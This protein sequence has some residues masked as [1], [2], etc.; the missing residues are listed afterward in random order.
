MALAEGAEVARPLG[1]WLG[2]DLIREAHAAV[3]GV[4]R[5]AASM[6]GLAES[7][8]GRRL[9]K[10]EAREASGLATRTPSWREVRSLLTQMLGRRD[11]GASGP[12]LE[13]VQRILLEEIVD[14]VG[15]D[16]EKGSA[17]LG[18]SPPTYR[19]RV[20]ELTAS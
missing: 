4:A 15:G 8:F 3:G 12:L 11:I 19:L 5:R 13:R 14:Q 17:L 6:L 20:S 10:A 16:V 9:R 18:V 1:K 2:E 7:T